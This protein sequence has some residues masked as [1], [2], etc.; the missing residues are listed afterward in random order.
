M[1]F[2]RVLVVCEEVVMNDIMTI[3]TLSLWH[4]SVYACVYACVYVDGYVLSACVFFIGHLWFV[5]F[6]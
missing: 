1:G 6:I 5:V 3:G 2:K 4:H